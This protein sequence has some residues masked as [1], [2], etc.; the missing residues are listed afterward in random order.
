MGLTA[1]SLLDFLFLF[2]LLLCLEVHCDGSQFSV[3][4]LESPPAFSRLASA[5]FVFEVLDGQNVCRNCSI[6]CKLDDHISSDCQAR[7]ASYT[8]LHDGRHLFEVCINGSQ[9]AGCASYNWTVD[10]VRPTAYVTVETSFTNALNVTVN[11]SFTEPCIGGGGFGCLSV[12]SCNLLVY[13]AGQV[14]P[15]TLKILQ[16]DLIFSLVVGLSSSV[17]YGRIIVVMDTN[18]CTDSAG[19]PFTRSANSSFFVHFDRRNVFLNLRTGIPKQLLQINGETRTVEATN[20]SKNLKLYLYFSDP[21]LNSSAEILA[22]LQMSQGLLLPTNGN[23][24]GNRRFSFLVK[25]ISNVSVVTISFNSSSI[26]SRHGTP[27]SPIAPV[28]FLYDRQRPTVRLTTTS[29]MRT[30]E[31][32][33]P[34]LIKFAKPIF[35]FNHSAISISG[36]HLQSFRE[37]SRSTYAVEIY[38]TDKSV[39]IHVPENITADVAGNRNLE[40]NTLQVRHYSVPLISSVFST[41]ATTAFAVTSSASGLLTVSTA[42]LQSIGALSGLSS[43]TSD[44]ARNLFRIACHIQVFALSRWLGVTIPVEYYEFARGLQWT[45]PYL[46]LPWESEHVQSVIVDSNSTAIALSV[47]LENHKGIY[48]SVQSP[49][50]N[51]DMSASIYGLPLTPMEYRSYFEGQNMKP[52]ADN[53]LDQQNSNG[54]REFNRNIFWL[55]VTGGGLILLHVI[56]LFVLRLRK[57]SSEKQGS[58]GAL[59]FPRFEMFLIVLALPCI[60]QASAAVIEGGTTSGVIVGILLLA[61]ES[62]LLLALLLFLSGGITIGKLLQYKEVHQEGQKFHWYQEIVRVTLGPGKRG[63]WTW[64]NQ[65]NSIYPTILGPLFEDLRGPP[66]YMLSQISGGNPGKQ[67]DRIIASDDETE[68]AEAPFIQKLFGI[69]RIYYAFLEAVKRFVLGILVGAYSIN[70][71]SRTPAL[72]LVCITSFQLFFLVL[73][74]PFIKKKVQLVEILTIGSEVGIFSTCLVLSKKEFSSGD[75]TRIGI[76]M[77]LLFWIG[78]SAQMIN[79]WYALY[80][81]TL[82]LGPANSFL[83]GLRTA[84]VGLLLILIPLN[85]LKNLN[86]EFPLNQSGGEEKEGSVTF[87]DRDRSSGSKSSGT[88]DRPWMRQLRELAKASFSKEDGSASKDP[89][90]S[91]AQRS[92]SKDPSTSQAQTSGFWSGKRSGS[93]S[94]TSFADYKPRRSRSLYRD[95]EAIFTSK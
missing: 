69:L 2:F 42:S 81:Q 32:S 18:F 21:V 76:F 66:K 25:N 56:V 43:L 82:L 39:S 13:G 65:P 8:G 84:C 35:G 27:V 49:N 33:V 37:I 3:N 41:F 83:S 15:S 72:T 19:N 47:V 53:I 31:H 58:Y 79:E 87:G 77:L 10:T 28:T 50:G 22:S 70:V 17:H 91:Q 59:I 30:R 16:P 62:F 55:A 63:Q 67:G 78:F 60:C 45:I 86:N 12:N 34:V 89:S 95:L 52:E 11:I 44:P 26:I 9:G 88:P 14:I 36:G 48:K 51:L 94:V 46:R 64:K 93:S 61:V 68:D 73:K 90:T 4:F 5:T 57:K 20:N 92:T 85:V 7:K 71:S 23:S 75:E 24:L 38:A 54:W 40:S 29:N 80:R 1:F 6:K 74:K